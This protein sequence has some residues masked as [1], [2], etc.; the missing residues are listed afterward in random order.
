MAH[1]SDDPLA[2]V[3]DEA[4]CCQSPKTEGIPI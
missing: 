1:M 3:I 2:Q 4:D